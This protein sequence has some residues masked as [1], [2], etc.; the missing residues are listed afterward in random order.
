[1]D[2]YLFQTLL[3]AVEIEFLLFLLLLGGF[4][5]YTC[6]Y[7][8][9]VIDSVKILYRET[10]LNLYLV[11]ACPTLF[12][13]YRPPFWLFS[14]HLQGSLGLV[15]RKRYKIPYT[16]E[17][18]HARDGAEL[19]LNWAEK[20]NLSNQTP[21][22]LI[23]PGVTG[24]RDKPYVTHLVKDAYDKN[25]RPVVLIFPGCLIDGD[26]TH[27]CTNARFYSP[28]DVTDVEVVLEHIA[29]K[30]PD[31]PIIGV[32][33]SMGANMLVKYLGI[34]GQN[35][36]LDSCISLSNPWCWETVQNNLETGSFVNRYVLNSHFADYWMKVLK[37]NQPHFKDHP[38]LPAC[39]FEKKSPS[40]RFLDEEVTS[41]IYGFENMKEY[42]T[43]VSCKEYV[44]NVKTPLFV[45]HALD[46]PIVPTSA[47]P[48]T[49]LAKNPNVIVAI[50]KKGGHTGWL[51][52]FIPSGLCFADRLCI[53]F[54]HAFIDEKRPTISF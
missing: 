13:K 35:S 30:Y 29:M 8:F 39:V 9:F 52:G 4:F 25:W 38:H 15:L 28:V 24:G 34:A 5:T 46:D 37:Q 21:V 16:R 51:E 49:V 45:I 50:T 27:P 44:A 2:L 26:E 6:Y 42:Y 12:S 1:M 17:I 14:S 3:F 33:H 40:I 54:I 18:I 41:K 31:A 19:L 23:L 48:L 20:D 47:L 43:A 36:L 11:N 53:E 22:L 32:G 10:K 7:W